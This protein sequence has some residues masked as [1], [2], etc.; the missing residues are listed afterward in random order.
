MKLFAEQLGEIA[1]TE[2]ASAASEPRGN[3]V[4]QGRAAHALAAFTG[5]EADNLG[6][7]IAEQKGLQIRGERRKSQPTPALSVGTKPNRKC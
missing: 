4:F 7:K 5:G 1:Q 3:V 2:A 6:R